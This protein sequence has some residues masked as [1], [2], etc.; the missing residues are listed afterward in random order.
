MKKRKSRYF[1]GGEWTWD[2]WGSSFPCLSF[3][4]KRSS[5]KMFWIRSRGYFHGQEILKDSL[6]CFSLG[7]PASHSC[8]RY[9]TEDAAA[10]GTP[11][12]RESAVKALLFALFLGP[13]YFMWGPLLFLWAVTQNWHKNRWTAFPF[14][15]HE[16]PPY[17]EHDAKAKESPSYSSTC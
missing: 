13:T 16:Q 2:R 1:F 15:L 17:P 4:L 9:L 6:S 14:P 3:L 8:R 10:T 7:T 11:P 12:E 5:Q